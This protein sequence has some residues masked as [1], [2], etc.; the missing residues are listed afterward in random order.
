MPWTRVRPLHPILP[1]LNSSGEVD[2]RDAPPVI[3]SE[4]GTFGIAQFELT[5]ANR[6]HADDED[7]GDLALPPCQHIRWCLNRTWRGRCLSPARRDFLPSQG[8]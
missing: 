2:T 7:P 1:N 4:P 6:T 5:L 8:G 3:T